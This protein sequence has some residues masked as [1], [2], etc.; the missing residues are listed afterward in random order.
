MKPV[1]AGIGY[2]RLFIFW[3]NLIDY[4]LTIMYYGIGGFWSIL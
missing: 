1:V 3:A 4:I 2:S